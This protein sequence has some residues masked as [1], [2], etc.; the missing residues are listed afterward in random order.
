MRSIPIMQSFGFPVCF[1]ATHAV[2][3]PGSN[4]TSSGGQRE[5][6]P[7]L[8]KSAIAAGCNC[9]FMESHPDPSHALSD[10][11][12]VLPFSALPVLLKTLRRLYEVIQGEPDICFASLSG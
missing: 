8:A 9:L 7:I 10:K 6:I 1:D 11:D 5:F 12:S 2:Q 3:L 4:G